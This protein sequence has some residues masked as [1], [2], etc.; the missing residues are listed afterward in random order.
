MSISSISGASSSTYTA[1]SA[2]TSTDAVSQLENQKTT[3]E[4]QLKTIS[5][6]K[7]DEKTK[8]QKTKDVE[9]QIAQ[10]D[11]QIQQAKA[12]SGNKTL[13]S[14]ESKKA[15]DSLKENSKDSNKDEKTNI[16]DELA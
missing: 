12:A 3:L 7:D 5:D 6:S 13:A 9:A 2:S 1:V 4:A 15:I 14:S 10:I 11:A 8:A 16:I